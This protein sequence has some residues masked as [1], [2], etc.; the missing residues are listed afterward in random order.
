MVVIVGLAALVLAG[1]ATLV[2]LISRAAP[3]AA[4]G[5][6]GPAAGERQVITTQVGSDRAC[7]F[8]IDTQAQGDAVFAAIRFRSGT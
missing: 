2:V 4:L 1:V 7:T 5:I 8:D 3:G 6:S